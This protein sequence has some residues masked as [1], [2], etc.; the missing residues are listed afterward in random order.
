MVGVL[1]PLL[2]VAAT[3]AFPN[4]NLTRLKQ[5]ERTLMIVPWL[6]FCFAN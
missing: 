3:Q 2:D 1:K 4:M 5:L 6:E